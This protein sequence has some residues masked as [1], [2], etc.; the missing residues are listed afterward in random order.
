[1]QRYT[2]LFL[3]LLLLVLGGCAAKHEPQWVPEHKPVDPVQPPEP[4]STG[5][6]SLWTKQETSLFSDNKAQATG[7]IVT[8]A[9]SEQAQASKDASTDTGRT[10]NI[11]AGIDNLFGIPNSQAILSNPNMDLGNLLGA[12][13]QNTFEG[14]GTTTRNANL[15]ATIATQVIETLPNG[16]LRIFGRKRVVVNNEEEFIGLSGIVRPEDINAQNVVD[17][18]YVL[19]AE[20]TYTGSGAISDKQ[21]PGWLMRL[22]DNAWPF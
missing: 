18:S 12:D 10:T 21:Q 20:I 11:N 17:S 8:V 7:D 5:P 16:N 2:I 9:I 4:Q 19:D 22:I 3:A 15:S 13:F 14:S 1:M 6:G